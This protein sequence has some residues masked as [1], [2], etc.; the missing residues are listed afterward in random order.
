MSTLGTILWLRRRLAIHELSGIAGAV[1]L[2]AGLALFLVAAIGALAVA[3]GLGVVLHL[4]V[5]SDD[6]HAVAAAWSVTLYTIAFFALVVP[7]IVGAGRTSFDPARLLAFPVSRNTLFRLSLLSDFVSKIHLAWYPTLAVAIVIG[8][9]IPVS[10]WPVALVGLVLFTANMVVWS[11]AAL[12]AVRRVLRDRR[13]REI[14]AVLGLALLLPIVFLPAAV[15]IN[16][17]DAEQSLDEIL[18]IPQWIGT[19]S[20]VL[21]PSITTMI[22]AASRDSRQGDAWTGI[23]WLSIWLFGGLAAGVTAF[24]RLLRCDT[25]PSSGATT[26]RS[27]VSA[28]ITAIF[29]PLPSATGAVAAKELRYLMQS[30]VGKISLL[31]MPLITAVPAIISGR[32]S[33]VQIA[34]FDLQHAVFFGI[35]IYT[36]ALTGYLQVNTFAWDGA[37]LAVAFNAPAN[38]ENLLLGKNLGIWSFNALLALEGLVAWGLVHSFPEPSAVTSGLLVLASTT[39]LTSLVGNFTSVAFPVPRPIETVTSA[40]SPVGT[41]VMIGC[42]LVG[43]ML[44]GATAVAAVML[45][46][47]NLQ[48]VFMLF[49]F[50]A[51]AGVYRWSLNP[52]ARALGDQREEVLRAISAG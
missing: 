21:P 38:I 6:S 14:A 32:H 1:N 43:A 23:A 22:L 18:T 17:V 19:A 47:P 13:M 20:S 12:L 40:A 34:G 24:D 36:V 25:S 26:G 44:A 11:H 50:V 41:L 15:D 45:G 42:L 3:A 27:R 51:I 5:R 37:G 29:N 4:A 48:P 9:L 52:A 35:M 8:V 28:L 46:H 2:A 7:I 49:A 30:G 16:A 31:V 10:P 33:G 39:A